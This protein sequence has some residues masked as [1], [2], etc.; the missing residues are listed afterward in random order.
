M[1]TVIRI[2]FVLI[3][4][5]SFG[6][7]QSCWDYNRLKDTESFKETQIEGQLCATEKTVTITQGNNIVELQSI[8]YVEDTYEGQP[9]VTQ[10][11]RDKNNNI[12]LLHYV[13]SL[14]AVLVESHYSSFWL[15]QR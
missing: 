7:Q 3:A 12:I 4:S 2:L 1:D 13:T 11:V 6:Q 15:L 10:T 8:S 9:M 5:F 14:D